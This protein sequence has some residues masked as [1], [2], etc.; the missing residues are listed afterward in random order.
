[1]DNSTP[2]HASPEESPAKLKW[3]PK[4]KIG[5]FLLVANLPMGLIGFGVAGTM[6]ALTGRKAFWGMIGVII[7]GLSWAM[8]GIGVLL[9]GPQGVQYVRQLKRKWLGSR[10]QHRDPNSQRPTPEV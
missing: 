3:T 2:E 7:Y 9:A 1:M 6:A 5:I 8:L 4:L 10:E